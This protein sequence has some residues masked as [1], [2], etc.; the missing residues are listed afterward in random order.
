MTTILSTVLQNFRNY[1]EV[2]ALGN[3]FESLTF[4][5]LEP[6]VIDAFGIDSEEY[7]YLC[8]HFNM[9]TTT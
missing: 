6:A 7:E 1:N 8:S 4:Q 9:A 3:L 2:E 5:E